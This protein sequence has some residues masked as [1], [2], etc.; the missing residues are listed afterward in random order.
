MKKY[1]NI[2]LAVELIPESDQFIVHKAQEIAKEFAAK[3]SVLHVIEHVSSY[4][5]AYGVAVGAD[6]EQMLI[7]NAKKEMAKLGF[8]MGIS[9][10]EQLLRVG[11]AGTVILEEAEKQKADLIIV[12]SHGR[13]GIRLL[14]GSPQMLFCMAR[15]AMC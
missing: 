7:D 13:H 12:G 15:K 14:L 1:Q 11:P 8:K 6:I 10:K 2:L 5:A 9:E 3:L 4:G